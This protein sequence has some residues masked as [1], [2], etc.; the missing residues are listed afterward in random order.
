MNWVK[1]SA[2]RNREKKRENEMDKN[3]A[4]LTDHAK[5]LHVVHRPE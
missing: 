4:K 2:E 1:I 5:I 3:V